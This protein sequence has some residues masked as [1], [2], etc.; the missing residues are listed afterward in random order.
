MNTLRIAYYITDHFTGARL[1]LGAMVASDG[2]QSFVANKQTPADQCVGGEEAG[3]AWR[4]VVEMLGQC[5]GRGL[6]VGTGPHVVLGPEIQVAEGMDPVRL[7]A[8]M[9]AQTK[10]A[11]AT[12][13][14][15]K[16]GE[17]R[18][19]AGMQ[20]LTNWRVDR[21]VARRFRG[22]N[23]LPSARHL[24]PISHYVAGQTTTLLMEPFSLDRRGW[25]RDLT[26][27]ATRTGAFAHAIEADGA[28]D[29]FRLKV[30]A[31]E[32]G[33]QGDR[34]SAL[35]ELSTFAEVVDVA[36]PSAR[37]LFLDE[38]RDVGLRGQGVVANSAQ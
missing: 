27:I 36:D 17:H 14:R 10:Y 29:Q 28:G 5:D 26:D 7:A 2:S 31:L 15:G 20:F 23:A 16:R 38:V 34:D 25:R 1:P 22:S 13:S 4:R 12:K 18:A 19:T 3:F 11:A 6:P 30:Y 24:N 9:L 37:R 32:G 21:F 35:D 33:K 8:S